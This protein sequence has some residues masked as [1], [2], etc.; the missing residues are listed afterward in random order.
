MIMNIPVHTVNTHLLSIVSWVQ[1]CHGLYTK[2]FILIGMRYVSAGAGK[3]CMLHRVWLAILPFNKGQCFWRCPSCLQ[4]QHP[5]PDVS[6]MLFWPEKNE[7][8][9]LSI[10]QHYWWIISGLLTQSRIPLYD[11]PYYHHGSGCLIASSKL[12][13]ALSSGHSPYWVSIA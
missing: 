4:C 6:D 5:S 9:W 1:Q 3:G 8:I 7:I 2:H 12:W 11:S 13:I 10:V